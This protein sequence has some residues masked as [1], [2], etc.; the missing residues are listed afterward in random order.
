[1]F[2]RAVLNVEREFGELHEPPG[3][4]GRRVNVILQPSQRAAVGLEGKVASLHVRAKDT[5]SPDRCQ[6]LPFGG[7][8][9]PLRR[10]QRTTLERDGTLNTVNH[11]TEDLA[12][13]VGTPI[14]LDEERLR[15]VGPGKNSVV[16]NA[17]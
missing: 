15:V 6:S 16:D 1:V 8:I 2:A 11:L 7:G 3:K 5:H 13:S 17:G 12:N 14:H 4:L 9:V 10:T